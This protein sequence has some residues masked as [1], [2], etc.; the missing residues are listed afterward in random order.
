MIK[1]PRLLKMLSVVFLFI[2]LCANAQEPYGTNKYI[3]KANQLTAKKLDSAIYYLKAG[4]DYYSKQKDTINLIN[5][6]CQ[7][8][9]V[10]DNVLDYG[11]SYDGYWEALIL[12][13]LSDD[14]ISKSR[15]YQELG[16]LYTAYRREEESLRYFN[17]SLKLKKKLF[18]EKKISRDYLVSNYFAIVNC[19]R[20]NHNYVMAKT[21]L[22]SCELSLKKID[23]NK[24][25]YYV[26]T[27]K[28]YFDAV[29]GNYDNA[30]STL[31]D[32]KLFFEQ[33]SPSYL[34]VVHF[35][36]GEVHKLKGN[37]EEA[38]MH[39]KESLRFSEM[40]NKHLGYKLF[41]YEVLSQ[42]YYNQNNYKEAFFYK[43]KA[44]EL[45][46]SIF[47]RKS[48]NH[49]H[50]FEIKDRYRLQKEKEK[51]LLKEVRIEKLEDQKRIGFLQNILMG[52]VVVFMFLYGFLLFRN[53]RRKH[54]LEKQK[55]NEVMMLKNRELTASALQLIEK[56][57][58]IAKLKQN[59]SKSDAIDA[60]AIHNMLKGFQNSPGG[61]WKEFEARFTSIN[62]SFYEKI[63]SKYPDLGQ[64][65]L[66]LCALVKLG[67]SSK[68]M[69]SL[70]GITIES[71]HTSRYRLRKK[72]KLEKGENLIDFMSTI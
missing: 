50:L 12:A 3:E 72:L 57:E 38:I 67:F 60:K 15:I 66:K 47:G 7:L 44:Q 29:A 45:N 61:N 31:N 41:N 4:I 21:Y 55:T 37:L 64:T 69:S 63:R 39:Y 49:K 8:S 62:Q 23:P 52:V 59:I 34:T 16:W 27:E 33:K 11:K 1:R 65:D 13:D 58:F 28:G 25:S 20:V 2:C 43:N 54:K 18:K 5:N 32:T 48:K 6:L 30:L 17:M 22:D 42:I 14:D 46:E 56:E 40:Y 10:Y 9:G 53:L 24:K 70:L 35:L 26:E 36:M 19:Y 71:V 51:A 68:E